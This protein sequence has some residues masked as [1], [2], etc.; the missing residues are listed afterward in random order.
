MNT[1][2]W[3]LL[4]LGVVLAVSACGGGGAEQAEGDAGTSATWPRDGETEPSEPLA[5]EGVEA[6]TAPL[7]TEISASGVVRGFREARVISETQGIIEE[8]NFELGQRV[9]EDEV[10]VGLDGEIARLQ[11]EQA[12]RQLET[13]QFELR[14]TERLAERGSASQAELARVRASAIGAEATFEQAKKRFEDRSITAP[15]SGRIAAKSS[16]ITPG[17]Y[18]TPNLEVARIVNLDMLEMEIAVGEREVGYLAEGAPATVEIPACDMLEPQQARVVSIAAGSD[19]ATG[20]FPAVIRWENTCGEAVRSGMTARVSI[21]PQGAEEVLVVPSGAI[22]R[23]EEGSFVFLAQDS[24]VV[25]TRVETG[26]RLGNRTEIVQGISESDVVITTAITRL[27]DG[28]PVEVDVVDTS[29]EA[30]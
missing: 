16:R 20:S 1:A 2:R 6:R 24:T 28:D 29:G 17:E 9:E 7:V 23:E 27:R 21:P 22:V 13:I 15:I 10:L 5:V 14:A 3:L 26:R 30:L 8:V 25:R 12:Q 18:L 19:P 4:V 11:M